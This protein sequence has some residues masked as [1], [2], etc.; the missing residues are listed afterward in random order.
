[1][2]LCRNLQLLEEYLRCVQLVTNAKA[3]AGFILQCKFWS[4]VIC[5]STDF[6]IK[7]YFFLTAKILD[8]TMMISSV[9]YV[10]NIVISSWAMCLVHKLYFRCG[11]HSVSYV[12][13][14]KS[15]LRIKY[16]YFHTH[17]KLVMQFLYTITRI[18]DIFSE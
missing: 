17:M 12:V 5:D 13:L 6:K 8:F 7:I 14:Y 9:M 11:D 18:T 3:S 10:C 1:M 4:M 16:R 2:V 15:T